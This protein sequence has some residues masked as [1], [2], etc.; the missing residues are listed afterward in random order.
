MP[1]RRAA[2][3]LGITLALAVPHAALASRAKDIVLGSLVGTGLGTAFGGLLFVAT[4]NNEDLLPAFLAAGGAVGLVGGG[5]WGIF[6]PNP[7]R[8]AEIEWGP[9]AVRPPTMAVVREAALADPAWTVRARVLDL[10]F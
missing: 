8:P 6:R 3:V 1:S 10:A 5:A 2:L 9:L 4:Q 7:W